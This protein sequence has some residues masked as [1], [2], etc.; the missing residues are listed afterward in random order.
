[1]SL[2]VYTDAMRQHVEQVVR[3]AGRDDLV[4]RQV[5]PP[6]PR[7][8]TSPEAQDAADRTVQIGP[9]ADPRWATPAPS[10]WLPSPRHLAAHADDP[11]RRSIV[12]PASVAG[13]DV[14]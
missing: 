13:T 5:E 3:A 11:P 2:V 14:N 6:P 7:V 12:V 10:G 4:I 1:M 9:D 8:R